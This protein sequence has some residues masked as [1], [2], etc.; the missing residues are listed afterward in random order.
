M[1]EKS[2]LAR[3]IKCFYAL[4]KLL[5]QLILGHSKYKNQKRSEWSKVK[6]NGLYRDNPPALSIS[7][8]D[9]VGIHLLIENL[10][11]LRR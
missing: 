7:N 4:K 6:Q 5:I 1:I 2:F 3:Q 9:S 11:W 8:S 10:G